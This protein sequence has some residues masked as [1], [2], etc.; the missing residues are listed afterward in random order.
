[1]KVIPP[2]EFKQQLQDTSDIVVKKIEVAPTTKKEMYHLAYSG[3]G[4][5]FAY[6]GNLNLLLIDRLQN[7]LKL[8][9]GVTDFSNVSIFVFCRSQD[10][11]CAF[12]EAIF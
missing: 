12:V 6:P 9:S 11:K 10:S 4:K 8:L 7:K 1:V 2:S 3:V 5:Y